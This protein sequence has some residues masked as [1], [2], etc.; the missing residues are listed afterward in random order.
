MVR[1]KALELVG[2]EML[3]LLILLNMEYLRINIPMK[4][5]RINGEF[6][7]KGYRGANNVDFLAPSVQWKKKDLRYFLLNFIKD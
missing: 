5:N 4:K 3:Y 7:R 6:C 1:A 2:W